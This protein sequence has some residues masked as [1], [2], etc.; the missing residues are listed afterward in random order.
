M[1]SFLR[2]KVLQAQ[3]HDLSCVLEQSCPV[4]LL[5]LL[6]P[7]AVDTEG[8]AVYE[9]ANAA[10]G[11][12]VSGQHLP[13]E[14]PGPAVPAVH[15]DTGQHAHYQHLYKSRQGSYRLLCENNAVF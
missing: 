3:Q 10:Q 5:S 4:L 8:A 6:H 2:L 13:G 11:V 14:R 15:P 1:E 9:F 12:R 7:V